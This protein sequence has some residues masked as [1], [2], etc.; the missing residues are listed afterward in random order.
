MKVNEP[1]GI[2]QAEVKA[3]GKANKAISS[4]PGLKE[5]TFDNA[6]V[7][8]LDTPSQDFLRDRAECPVNLSQ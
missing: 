5:A 2:P 6:R 4:Y 3:V 8:V 7:C 1:E